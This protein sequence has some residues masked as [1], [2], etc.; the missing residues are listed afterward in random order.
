MTSVPGRS[1][2]GAWRGAGDGRWAGGEGG[3]GEAEDP[4]QSQTLMPMARGGRDPHLRERVGAERDPARREGL[5]GWRNPLAPQGPPPLQT[6]A[7]REGLW[8]SPRQRRQLMPDAG[9]F[10]SK[11]GSGLCQCFSIRVAS[12]R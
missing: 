4:A 6:G 8:P 1:D 3:G 10:I 5:T 12:L 2:L 9:I 7:V 11:P